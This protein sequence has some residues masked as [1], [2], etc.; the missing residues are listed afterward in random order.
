MKSDANCRIL[1]GP[2]PHAHGVASYGRLLDGN[3]VEVLPIDVGRDL[4]DHFL[5]D[6]VAIISQKKDLHAYLNN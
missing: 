4:A 6:V 5:G 3:G 1:H 2:C